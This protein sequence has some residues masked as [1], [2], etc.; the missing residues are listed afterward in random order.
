[1]AKPT[2]ASSGAPSAARSALRALVVLLA[3]VVVAGLALVQGYLLW[4]LAPTATSVGPLAP[5]LVL[6]AGCGVLQALLFLVL[7]P[8][9]Y[10]RPAGFTLL[11][12]WLVCS[13][14]PFFGGMILLVSC[15]WAAV[16]PA[17]RR[18]EDMQE[19]P[20][21]QFVTYLMSRVSHGGGAR[22]QARLVNTQ[23]NAS[24]RLS[25]LVA[26]Q[27]MPTRTTGT[28]LRD[29]LA[30]PVEDVRLIAYGTL[31]QAENEVMQKIFQTAQTLDY[32]ATD[33]ERHAINR[34][35]A[36]LY[37][38]LVYQNLV[39]G[40]VYRHTLE[41]ADRYARAALEIDSGDAALWMI[42]GRLA[43]A[44]GAAGE[45]EHH[46]ARAQQLGFP[47]ERLVPWMAEVA[48]LQGNYARVSE[49]LGSLT[50]A[51]ALPMLNPVVRYWST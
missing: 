42:R 5:A 46:M 9:R 33:S 38:E 48:F 2:S 36:E 29:L 22:L 6:N 27:S 39:Q 49:L 3:F 47:R 37:F 23:V 20:T 30:D 44:N 10:R 41:Q 8:R 4:Q 35:L 1:M 40:A 24:D 45:A 50:N 15:I 25:A 26:I 21:P 17:R 19:V 7:L 14:V 31:D 16:F 51:A 28:L 34:Q 32:A 43:L 11:F 13:F 18:D 12:L